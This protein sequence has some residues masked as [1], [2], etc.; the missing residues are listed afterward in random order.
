M[1]VHE[2]TRE[3]RLAASVGSPHAFRLPGLDHPFLERLAPVGAFQSHAFFAAID[4]ALCSGGRRELILIGV[5]DGEGNAVAL[6]PFIR[7]R[8]LGATILEGLDL[9]VTDYFAP[10]A[11][12]HILGSE[13]WKAVLAALPRA[14]AIT[15][16]K[17]PL[18]LHG[19]EH[20]LTDAPFLRPMG[21]AAYTARL[22]DASGRRVRGA[23][24]PVARDVRRKLRK[25]EAMGEV[26]FEEATSPDDVTDAIDRLVEFRTTRFEG[27]GRRD[28]LT[29]EEY[30]DF[31]RLLASGPDPIGRLFSLKVGGDAVAVIYALVDGDTVTLVIPSI[32][33]D[34]RWH[35]A[36]PGLIALHMLYEWAVSHDYATF[37]FSVGSAAYKMRFNTEKIDL[38]EYQQ[39]LTPLGL[40]VVA[41]AALRRLLRRASADHP[42]L[43]AVLRRLAAFKC[44]CIAGL[45]DLEVFAPALLAI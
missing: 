42:A 10:P 27:M 3:A 8:S 9:Q 16:K 29:M 25:L 18:K 13:L 5:E 45:L 34:P 21:A 22:H 38:Y 2:L 40:P 36:S 14:D 31:Y 35:V 33:S 39:A 20:A 17:L 30:R 6:F 4:Q 26:S 43:H 23:D 11:T 41:N 19:R 32:S 28:I 24:L 12:G 7:R 37:D 44:F 1:T 15:F